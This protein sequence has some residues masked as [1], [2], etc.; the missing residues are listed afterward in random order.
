[1]ILVLASGLVPQMGL[2]GFR[3]TLVPRRMTGELSRKS[4][5]ERSSIQRIRAMTE[6]L[7]RWSG[8]PFFG[9][10]FVADLPRDLVIRGVP[11]KMVHQS[12]SQYIDVLLKTGAVGLL[13][14]A[15][16]YLRC[17]MWPLARMALT[18]RSRDAIMTYGVLLSVLVGIAVGSTFYL[19]FTMWTTGVP[20]GLISGYM[21]A[22]AER[23]LA[24][25]QTG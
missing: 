4:S 18:S 3:S 6:G 22:G 1:M 8:A 20:L 14:M 5:L 2:V 7:Q 11:Q 21:V 13:L 9:T 15:A 24:A 16:F 10:F 19:Y 17:V 23:E 25:R 12:H